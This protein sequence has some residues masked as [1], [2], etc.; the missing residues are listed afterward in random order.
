MKRITRI[1]LTVASTLLI[2]Y[3]ITG[4]T[5]R[6]EN[7]NI[8]LGILLITTLSCELIYN[9][10]DK[11][12]RVLLAILLIIIG[13]GF[14]G[15]SYVVNRILG[16][17]VNKVDSWTTGGHEICLVSRI[18]IAGPLYYEFQLNELALFGLLRKDIDSFR[19]RKPSNCK[20]SFKSAEF[21]FNRCTNELKTL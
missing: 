7:I 15:I 10:R 13:S 14:I 9:I 12:S 4:Y 8:I 18:G 21:E 1:T 11:S 6:I 2:I 17:D 16:E 20:I 19:T 5:L 3:W